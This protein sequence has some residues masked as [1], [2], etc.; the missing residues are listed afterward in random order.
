MFYVVIDLEW[1]QY[2]NPLWTPESRS[3]VIMQAEVSALVQNPEYTGETV[4]CGLAETAGYTVSGATATDVGDY[5]ATVTPKAG[6]V[7]DDGTMEA[8]TFS[9]SVAAS[10]PQVAG[11]N[12]APAEVFT[13]A[14]AS[15]PIVYPTEPTV[16]GEVGAQVISFGGVDVNVP[17]YYTASKSGNVVS[18][19]L[20]D[21]AKPVITDED[22]TPGIAIVD[23][24]V[25]IHLGNV[26]SALYY[27]ILSATSLDVGEWTPCGEAEQG[28]DDFE[29]NASGPVRFYKASV[30]DEAE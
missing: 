16:T 17:D 26:K 14:K 19:V 9:W 7:W 8:K 12:V 29:Y 11:E 10:T 5:T 20:N 28:Q 13:K 25:H 15:K 27:T 2:H 22:E 6:Y 1:N 24:K 18:L 4:S 30:R 21:N 3:G 23:G